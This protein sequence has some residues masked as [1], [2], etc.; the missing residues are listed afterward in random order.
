MGY[1]KDIPDLLAMTEVQRADVVDRLT[2]KA[3]RLMDAGEV[4]EATTYLN[5]ASAVVAAFNRIEETAARLTCALRTSPGEKSR[6][7]ADP[8]LGLRRSVV[9]SCA[10]TS[11]VRQVQPGCMYMSRS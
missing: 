7:T 8:Q 4:T 6:S 10:H 1:A 5:R 2:R 9:R 3:F 11:G